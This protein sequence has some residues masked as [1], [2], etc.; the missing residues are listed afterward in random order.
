MKKSHD[1]HTRSLY[2][3]MWL[4]SNLNIN[5]FYAF[6]A[7]HLM[8]QR[9]GRVQDFVFFLCLVDFYVFF[10]DLLISVPYLCLILPFL[11]DICCSNYFSGRFVAWTSLS[12][13]LLAVNRILMTSKSYTKIVLMYAWQIHV[14]LHQQNLWN[15]HESRHFVVSLNYEF[16]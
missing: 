15:L 5:R 9:S 8:F 7:F 16:Y 12:L 11:V 2:S 1:I 13:D 4:H 3:Y 14:K 10:T 6:W